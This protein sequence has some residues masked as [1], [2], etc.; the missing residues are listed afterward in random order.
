MPHSFRLYIICLLGYTAQ[1]HT[2]MISSSVNFEL[3]SVELPAS[4]VTQQPV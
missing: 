3:L 4:Y 1:G 2:T